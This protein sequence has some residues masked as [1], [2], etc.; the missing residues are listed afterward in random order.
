M[1]FSPKIGVVQTEKGDG[2]EMVLYEFAHLL[3]DQGWNV[4]GLA[5]QTSLAT[6][7]ATQMELVDLRTK[8]RYLISQPLGRDSKGCCLD[9][10]GLCDSSAVL[11]REIES[12]VDLL[13]INKFAVAEAE[14]KGLLQ[15]LFMAIEQDIPVLTSVASRY[16]EDWDRLMGEYGYPIAPTLEA[17]TAWWD[18]TSAAR[19]TH[20][21]SN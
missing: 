21:T 8:D 2:T 10:S 1:D 15:E 5:Q 7:G 18:Q 16:K 4:G 20:V 11:R 12:R 14:G 17:L 6:N 19:K 9:A 13:I 3:I